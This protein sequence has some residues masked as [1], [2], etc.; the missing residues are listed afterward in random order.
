MCG[1]VPFEFQ[2]QSALDACQP[3]IEQVNPVD[4]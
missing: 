2:L 1:D 3:K 4:R